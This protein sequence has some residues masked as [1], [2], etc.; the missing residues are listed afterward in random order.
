MKRFRTIALFATVA[1]LAGTSAYAGV[2]GSIKTFMTENVIMLSAEA[3]FALLGIFFAGAAIYKRAFKETLDVP[4][5]IKKA[6]DAKSP[7]G[8][9]IVAEERTAIGKEMGEAAQAIGE[10]LI[11]AKKKK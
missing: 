1:V 10:A 6:R 2:L 8:K 5:A 7:G 3:I 9:D 11:A 4:F